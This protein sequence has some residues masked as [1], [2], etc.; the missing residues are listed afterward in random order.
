MKQIRLRFHTAA[1]EPLQRRRRLVLLSAVV[2]MWLLA[3]PAPAQETPSPPPQLK[4]VVILTRHGVRPPIWTKEMLNQ[5]SAGAWPNWGVPPGY[6]TPHGKTLMKLFGAYDRAYLARAE[7]LS[8]TGCSDAGQVYFWADTGERTLETGRALATGMFPGCPVEV[9]S[10]PQGQHDPLFSPFEAGIKPPDRRLAAAA[11][12]GRIGANPRALEELFRPEL[13]SLERVLLGCKTESPCP[14]R[15][16]AVKKS[17]FEE[18]TALGPGEGDHLAELSGP[19]K[20]GAAF[21]EDFLLEYL[22]GMTGNQLG[23]GRINESNIREMLSLHAVHADLMRRTPTI[24]RAQASNLLSHVLKAMEQAVAGRG[25]PGALG[26]PGDRAMVIVGHDTNISNVAGALGL[27]WLIEGYQRDDTPPG[28]ALVFELWREP[29]SGFYTVRA[30]YTSQTLEQM[31][32]ARP[33]TLESPPARAP[34]FL[35]GSS[36]A[37]E[38]MACGWEA[39][40]R[41]MEGAIDPAFV[42]P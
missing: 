12:S 16:A 4:F 19:I 29:A 3:A 34:V 25:V 38:G 15:G 18:P 26:Q 7:L 28:G 14:P 41:T 27:S 33:L 5:Y 2:P 21:S 42:K 8:P 23:W 32:T 30:Y 1:A 35:P 37:D 17:L 40:R 13:E 10:L 11:V 20:T 36:A 9:H 39:F 6:L 31:R 24:A 22:D